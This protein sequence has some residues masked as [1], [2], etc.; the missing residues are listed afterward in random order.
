MTGRHV[1]DFPLRHPDIDAEIKQAEE[2]TLRLL[3]E[4]TE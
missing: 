4:V 2:E 3:R 1:P